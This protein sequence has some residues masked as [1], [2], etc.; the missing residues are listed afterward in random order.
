MFQ[1]VSLDGSTF[2]IPIYG[3]EYLAATGKTYWVSYKITSASHE[4]PVINKWMCSSGFFKQNFKLHVFVAELF[5]IV[6]Y[7]HYG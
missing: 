4:V 3:K 2:N 1:P 5:Y 7:Y 6:W